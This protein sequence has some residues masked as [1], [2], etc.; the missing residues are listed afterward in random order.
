MT[1]EATELLRTI[2]LRCGYIING[3]SDAK[4]EGKEIERLA[5]ALLAQSNAAPVL[6]G[7]EK[8]AYLGGPVYREGMSTGA[9]A[10]P[11]S[12]EEML[13]AMTPAESSF[14]DKL[15]SNAKFLLDCY[16]DLSE[17][18]AKAIAN[19]LTEAAAALSLREREGMSERQSYIE[20]F[21]AGAKWWEFHSTKGTMWTSDR[22]LVEAEAARRWDAAAPPAGGRK[23]K[24]V[25][26]YPPEPPS[27]VAIKGD[28]AVVVVEK[29]AW[30]DLRARYAALVES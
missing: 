18:E 25:L 26:T 8:Q 15:R 30:D 4:L 12:G 9:S 5:D 1:P 6:Y 11:D 22:H 19:K 27:W 10:A 24:P 17:S 13:E 16:N 23:G 7:P 20:T 14:P 29:A 21:V 3:Y 2:K 28:Q